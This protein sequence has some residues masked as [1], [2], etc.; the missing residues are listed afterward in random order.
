V[1]VIGI[2]PTARAALREPD[3]PVARPAGH[4]HE[5]AL[6]ANHSRRRG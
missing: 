1:L 2:D 4:D 6:L 5:I 3:L